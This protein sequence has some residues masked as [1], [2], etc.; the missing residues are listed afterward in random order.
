MKAPRTIIDLLLLHK[1]TYLNNRTFN[2]I[3]KVC[4]KEISSKEFFDYIISFASNLKSIGV[5]KGDKVAINLNN[6][7]TS[8]LSEFSIIAAEA[9]VVPIFNNICKEH[10]EY[11]IK[12]SN[13]TFLITDDYIDDFNYLNF[14]TVIIFDFFKEVQNKVKDRNIFYFSDLIKNE[15]SDDILNN[16]DLVNEDEVIYIIYSSG[17]GGMPKG[18]ELT[19]KNIISQIFDADKF[20]KIG[21]NDKA[22]SFLP[23]AHIFEKMVVLFY[24]YKGVRIYFIDDIKNVVNYFSKV[25]PD[26][27]TTVPR[28]LEKVYAKINLIS[29]DLNFINKYIFNCAVNYAKKEFINK[30]NIRYFL[31]NNLIYKKITKL[32]GANVR[33]IICGGSALSRNIEIFFRNIGLN[34]FCGYG[35]TE[36]SPVISA[37]CEEFNKIG[38]VGKAFSSVKIMIDKNGELLASGPNIMKGYHNKPELNKKVFDDNWLKTG[39][40]ALIDEEGFL[41][42]MGRKNEVIKNSNGKYI[43]LTKIEN[44][45]T[46][47]IDFLIGCLVIAEAK[48]FTSALLFIDHDNIFNLKKRFNI[49]NIDNISDNIYL[50]E[51]IDE[52]IAAINNKLDNWEDIKKYILITEKISIASGEITP[53]MKLKRKLLEKKFENQINSIYEEN[54]K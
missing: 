36:A 29:K 7:F 31:F 50:K 48:K 12:D 9:I 33:M 19:H 30:K 20:F 39:D 52:R 5:T 38:S 22:L 46:E 51:F 14:K 27:F 34:L 24:L 2:Y 3:S 10:F 26:L 54:E 16:Q 13:S 37:N 32:F 1:E 41:F 23:I 49:E 42:I 18:I 15:S 11:E 53:S 40:L 45:I 47:E 44:L 35:L 4:S 43:Q 6:N 17:T 28:V 21:V 8:L 25:N